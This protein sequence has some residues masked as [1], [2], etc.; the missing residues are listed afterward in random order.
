M[1]IAN[2][3]SIQLEKV[4]NQWTKVRIT[5][6]EVRKLIQLAMVPNKEVL[7]NIQAGKDDDLS[8]CFKNICDTAFEYAMSNPTQQQETTKGTLFSAYN[9]V[10]G[11]FQNVRN[12]K[13]DEA[14]LKSVLFGGTAQIR[15]QKAFELCNDFTN[16]SSTFLN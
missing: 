13:D 8:T 7:Q 6:K 16:N 4:F 9:A 5:D 14:K 1:G 3:L 15:T 12:Y 11:Y 2:G 10:T